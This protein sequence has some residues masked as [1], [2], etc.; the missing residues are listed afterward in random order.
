MAIT[1]KNTV[2]V[3]LSAAAGTVTIKRWSDGSFTIN[4]KDSKT[5]RFYKGEGGLKTLLDSLNG[6]TAMAGS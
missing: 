3:T 1:V 6:D 5:S 2:T 4:D